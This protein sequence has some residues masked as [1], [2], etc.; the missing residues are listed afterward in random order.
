MV[1]YIWTLIAGFVLGIYAV[2]FAAVHV[3]AF[4]KPVID[5][6]AKALVDWIYGSSPETMRSNNLYKYGAKSFQ[7]RPSYNPH[8]LLNMT[9]PTHQNTVDI[10]LGMENI[11]E[12]HGY[13]TVAD[14]KTA[15]GLPTIFQD[16]QYGWRKTDGVLYFT[17]NEAENSWNVGTHKHPEPIR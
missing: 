4:R 1:R 10:L 2:F 8:S 15:V 6:I 12:D 3:K 5:M 13:F 16:M 14:L 9:V 7:G 11:I 17:T